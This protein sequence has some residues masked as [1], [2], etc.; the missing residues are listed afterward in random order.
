MSL[1]PVSED[2]DVFVAPAAM[3]VPLT[4]PPLPSSSGP[5][6]AIK[7]G[8]PFGFGYGGMSAKDDC[9]WVSLEKQDA[10]AKDMLYEITGQE[11]VW[12]RTVSDR[13]G[14][15][16]K[17]ELQSNDSNWKTWVTALSH[18]VCLLGYKCG[19]VF[20][21]EDKQM[22][23]IMKLKVWPKDARKA[24]SEEKPWLWEVVDPHLEKVGRVGKFR[25]VHVLVAHMVGVASL[26]MHV[27]AIG[28]R[29][30]PSST[31]TMKTRKHMLSEWPSDTAVTGDTAVTTP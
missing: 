8:S 21:V 25:W 24:F 9:L 19:G 16:F 13:A 2:A 27:Y 15:I 10:G 14:K 20:Q 5:S 4:A 31:R 17:E 6:S 23:H 7:A 11:D 1:S 29:C 3:L 12:V 18:H 22:D 30:P 28:S 26:M